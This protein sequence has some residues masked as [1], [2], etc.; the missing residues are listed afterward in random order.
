VCGGRQ[1][2]QDW[3][4]LARKADDLG[5]STLLLPDHF[6]PQLAPLPALLAAA[7]ATP[8]LR[9][10]TVVLDNDFRHPA[11]LAKEAATIDLLTDGRLELGIGAGWMAA[12]YWASGL[13]FD[14]PGVR[15]ARLTEAIQIITAFFAGDGPVTFHGQYYQVDNLQPGPRP[16]QR[17]RPPIMIAGSRRRMLTLAA[18]EADIVGL[19]D[20]QFA[21]RVSGSPTVAVADC[22]EQVAIVREAAGERLA[23]I[24][25]NVFAARTV[26]TDARQSAVEEMA[27]QLQ[28]EPEQVQESPSFLIGSVE[29]IVDQLRARRE[30]FGISYVMIFDRVMDAFAPVVARLAGT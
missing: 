17:P 25:L 22:A 3:L 6:G 1:T 12:D 27:A 28:L 14:P 9:V 29:A 4:D 11:L 8:R 23:H 7:A 19:E 15:V 18:R 20:H 16:V 13:P 5:Y 10:G 21:D 24:E 30:R 2:R 26:V